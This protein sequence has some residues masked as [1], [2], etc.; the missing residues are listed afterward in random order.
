MAG[1]SDEL[2][3]FKQLLAEIL[4]ELQAIRIL[5]EEGERF[6]YDVIPDESAT[7]SGWAES[8]ND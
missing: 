7:W 3:Q 2:R 5:L 6:S 1:I 4:E 8:E